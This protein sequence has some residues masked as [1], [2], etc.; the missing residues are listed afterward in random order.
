MN[1]TICPCDFQHV[2]LHLDGGFSYAVEWSSYTWIGLWTEQ[3][4]CCEM[5]VGPVL[6]LESGP[7]TWVPK[8]SM[9]AS[10]LR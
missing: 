9:S 1:E 10:V 6:L 2:R 3:H 4:T 7:C 8:R 5:C